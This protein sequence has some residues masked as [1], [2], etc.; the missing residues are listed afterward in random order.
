MKK[1]LIFLFCILSLSTFAQNK[2]EKWGRFEAKFEVKT[3]KKSN[4]DATFSAIFST[5]DTTV[6]VAGFYNGNNTFVVR[7]MPEKLGEWQYTTKSNLPELN[8]KKGNFECIK[9]AANN[10]GMVKVSNVHHF[11]YAD[12][13]NY[14]PFGTTAY[15]WTH[16][17]DNIQETTLKTLKNSGFNKIR[18]GIFPKNYDLVKE[19]PEIYPYIIKETKK[20]LAGN[21]TKVWDFTQFNPIFFQKLEKRIDDLNDLGI[22]A[23]LILFHPYDKG[24]WGF[25]EMPMEVNLQ[26]I[27][28]LTARLSSF[29]NVWWSLANEYDYVKSKTDADWLTLTKE[30]VKNDPYRHLCSIHGSTAKYFDYWKPEFTH[31]SVQDEAP[32]MHWGAA[33]I[34]RNIYNKPIIYDEA[35]Y[36]GNLKHRWGRYSGE[37]MNHL[38]WMGVIGGTYVTHGES[39]IPDNQLI[40]T[41]STVLP[42]T[43]LRQRE[44]GFDTIFW[45]KGGEFKGTSWKRVAF[46]RKILEET[47]PIEMADVSRDFKTATNGKGSY[48]IYF[49]K[50]IHENWIFNLPHKNS[51]FDRP[52]AGIKYKVEIIDTWDMTIQSMPTVFEISEA[53]DYRVFDKENRKIRLPMKPFLALRISEY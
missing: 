11:K 53:N 15:A 17:P 52:K 13:I 18:M 35:G 37:E 6:S 7:F 47:G 42:S 23:D 49:G 36:E 28:Y 4:F 41:S 46:L 25:D 19:E 22:E 3:T 32:V 24:R 14:F 29:R 34:A 50:E 12:G 10:H 39:Y 8:N 43:S 44:M 26:Y 48:L 33:S 51:T 45:A 21:E 9:P 40:S 27:R 30:V 2:I 38:I 16:M 1:H 20:D 5:K 31:V